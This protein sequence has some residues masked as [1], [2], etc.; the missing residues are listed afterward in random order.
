MT[1]NAMIAIAIASIAGCTAVGAY[2]S[3]KERAAEYPGTACVRAAWNQADRLECVKAQ[4]I[5]I[6]PSS[7]SSN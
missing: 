6:K 7:S 1:E 3:S 2:S 5:T 4:V